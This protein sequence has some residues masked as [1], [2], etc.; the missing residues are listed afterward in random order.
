MSTSLVAIDLALGLPESSVHLA[1]LWRLLNDKQLSNCNSLLGKLVSWETCG[2][3][4][5]LR[6]P[7]LGHRLIQRGQHQQNLAGLGRPRDEGKTRSFGT[8]L[9]Q[10]ITSK[11]V[12][13]PN[14]LCQPSAVA[15]CCIKFDVLKCE[16]LHGPKQPAQELKV[17]WTAHQTQ[18]LKGR[19][20]KLTA[21]PPDPLEHATYCAGSTS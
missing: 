5:P 18:L 15:F 2:H 1:T 4:R 3:M 7:E 11:P 9:R 17:R 19:N 10:L 13:I 12:I 8:E 6:S 16:C 21:G 20:T 14:P